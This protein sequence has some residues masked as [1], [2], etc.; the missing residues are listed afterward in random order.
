MNY[1]RQ[2]LA[3]ELQELFKK[4]NDIFHV[5]GLVDRLDDFHIEKK[6]EVEYE[7][8]KMLAKLDLELESRSYAALKTPTAA[9]KRRRNSSASERAKPKAAIKSVMINEEPVLPVDAK[10]MRNE[11]FN[12]ASSEKTESGH[13]VGIS[14][15]PA[16]D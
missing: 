2:S 4:I 5:L 12:T 13:L 16:N 11:R 10:R 6:K 3:K 14:G 8:N 9:W 7:V 15:K 1:R